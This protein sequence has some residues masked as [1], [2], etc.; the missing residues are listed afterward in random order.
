MA[1]A[2]AG[3]GAGAG[4]AGGAGRPVAGGG[5]VTLA[6][7]GQPAVPLAS[8]EQFRVSPEV[9]WYA[10]PVTEAEVLSAAAGGALDV[11]LRRDGSEGAP[12]RLCGGRD[13]PT[14]PGA[15]GS[16]RWRAGRWTAS[17]LADRPLPLVEGRPV[18]GRYFVEL[19]F[20]DADGRP[21]VDIWF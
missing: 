14:R 6:V 3:A 19:R 17:D 10:Q 2:G 21:T 18:L 15:G 16:E 9:S 4:G 11:V 5:G 12:L 20:L 13:D 1:T 8:V 7:G